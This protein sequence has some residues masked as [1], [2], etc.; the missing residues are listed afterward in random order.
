MSV[1]GDLVVP[2]GCHSGK[3]LNEL[4]DGMVHAMWSSWNG[5]ARLKSHPFFL[6]VVSEKEFRTRQARESRRQNGGPDTVRSVD[7][8]NHYQWTDPRGKVHWIPNDVV[9]P[10]SAETNDCS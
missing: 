7:N 5:S 8:S 3:R 6:I 4:T 1:N 9:M 2:E 10:P